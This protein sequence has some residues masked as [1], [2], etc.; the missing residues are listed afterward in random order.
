MA[1]TEINP[2]DGLS[3]KELA[4]TRDPFKYHKVSPECALTLEAIRREFR[5]L[6]DYLK[7]EIVDCRHRAI[8]ITHLEDSLRSAV[9]ACVLS[10][11]DSE[12]VDE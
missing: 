4:A 2:Q 6:R 8:A 5:N 7:E 12:P 11:P 3:P 1:D 10:H 9:A